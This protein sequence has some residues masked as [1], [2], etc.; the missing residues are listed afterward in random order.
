MFTIC[1]IVD[2]TIF[3]AN[4]TFDRFCVLLPFMTAS[5]YHMLSSVHSV[6]KRYFILAI[7]LFWIVSTAASSLWKFSGRV[8]MHIE[9]KDKL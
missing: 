2:F 1:G 7:N 5:V 6:D 4:Y 9:I 3:L 8:V